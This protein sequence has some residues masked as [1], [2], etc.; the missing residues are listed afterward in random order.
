MAVV[1]FGFMSQ[2]KITYICN[3][4][5]LKQHSNRL[6]WLEYK[7][8]MALSGLL[9]D[10]QLSNY[11][12][13]NKIHFHIQSRTVV[14]LLGELGRESAILSLDFINSPILNCVLK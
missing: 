12:P 14:Q 5:K 8:F 11:F 10:F 1:Q 13:N 2:L 7:I 3:S 4:L 6:V 9:I